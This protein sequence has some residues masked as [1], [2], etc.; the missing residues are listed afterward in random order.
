MLMLI[1]K[2]RVV[3]YNIG[4]DKFCVQLFFMSFQAYGSAPP[5]PPGAQSYANYGQAPP[6]NFASQNY[7]APQVRFSVLRLLKIFCQGYGGSGAAPPPPP[8]LGINPPPS[9]QGGWGGRAGGP[10]ADYDY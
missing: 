6:Q 9:A 5:P 1:N 3:I 10:A 8:G 7:G 2:Y 4:V